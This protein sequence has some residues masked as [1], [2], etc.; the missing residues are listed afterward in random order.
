MY[1]FFII[2]I[3][4]AVTISCNNKQSNDNSQTTQPAEQQLNALDYPTLPNDLIQE[5]GTKGDHI[6]VLFYDMPISIS[7]DGNADVQQMLSHV[8][9]QAP[10]QVALCNPIGRIFFQGQGET[11]AEADLY[12]GENC[13][14]YLFMVNNKPTYANVLLPQGTQF[15]ENIIGPY[16]K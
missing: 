15:Y 16:R 9:N 7:R 14:Y 3:L 1:R 6:D 12:L 13:N 10:G 8:G 2:I 11:I 5:I 4:F